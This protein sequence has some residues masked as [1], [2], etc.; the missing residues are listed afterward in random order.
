MEI[1]GFT[2]PVALAA[3]MMA[4]PPVNI[5][6]DPQYH[7]LESLKALQNSMVLQ[8]KAREENSSFIDALNRNEALN[9]LCEEKDKAL[10]VAGAVLAEQLKK[11]AELERECEEKVERLRNVASMQQDLSV[12]QE[13][14]RVSEAKSK[15]AEAAQK[16]SQNVIFET[17]KNKTQTETKLNNRID[18]ITEEH[19]KEMAKQKAKSAAE[20][21]SATEL[22]INLI[23]S[24]NRG[25]AFQ[26]VGAN[27]DDLRWDRSKVRELISGGNVDNSETWRRMNEAMEEARKL[28]G[29]VT[30][31]SEGATEGLLVSG[32]VQVKTEKGDSTGGQ[33][34]PEAEVSLVG[35]KQ[36][37]GLQAFVSDEGKTEEESEDESDDEI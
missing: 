21:V 33:Q 14:L 5:P 23:N 16:L 4:P 20:T 28:D 17:V 29:D 37:P 36:E 25:N 30:V 15:K 6:I 31:K 8:Q 9:D 1:H 19:S 2:D 34:K 22:I 11:I 35:V 24:E 27:I 32:T 7:E 26:N 3:G 13:R 18:A 10:R 12:L